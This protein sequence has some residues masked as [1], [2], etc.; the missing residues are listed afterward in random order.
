MLE[1]M[2]EKTTWLAKTNESETKL[3]IP[4]MVKNIMAHFEK[5][6]YPTRIADGIS[7]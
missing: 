1:I 3:I 7:N 2:N 5:E 4:D 6:K